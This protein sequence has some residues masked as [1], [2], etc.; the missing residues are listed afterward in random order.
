MPMAGAC[1]G[2]TRR[3]GG[4]ANKASVQLRPREINRR[5][6]VSDILV[7]SIDNSFDHTQCDASANEARRFPNLQDA[8]T[9]HGVLR[10]PRGAHVLL[11]P[12]FIWVS[13]GRGHVQNAIEGI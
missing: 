10:V 9:Q 8:A 2:R 6:Q 1:V 4:G 5:Y 11:L 13:G 3:Q 7:H 12:Q